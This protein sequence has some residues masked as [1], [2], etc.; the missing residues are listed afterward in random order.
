MSKKS[1]IVLIIFVLI[2]QFY[3]DYINVVGVGG[4]VVR[5]SET[6][7]SSGKSE[8]KYHFAKYKSRWE[9]NIKMYVTGIWHYRVE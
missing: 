2:E 5:I 1:I 4:H 8:G 6:E 3:G 9:N 7:S